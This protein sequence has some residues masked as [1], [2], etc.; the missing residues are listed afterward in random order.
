MCICVCVTVRDHNLLLLLSFQHH[1]LNAVLGYIPYTCVSFNRVARS[2]FNNNKLY[3]F[4]L[5]VIL[6]LSPSAYT[7]THTHTHTHI[8]IYI[9]INN[10]SYNDFQ[11]LLYCYYITIMTMIIG[12]TASRT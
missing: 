4:F 12:R 11:R 1:R 9:C 2:I 8:H 10:L 3:H 5:D 6:Y 7:H